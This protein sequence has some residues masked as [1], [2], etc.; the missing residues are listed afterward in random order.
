MSRIGRN[1]ITVPAGVDV[2]IAEGNHITVKGALGTLEFKFSD[3]LNFFFYI[4]E[5]LRFAWL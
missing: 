1:P 3:I 2:V 4:T 5:I